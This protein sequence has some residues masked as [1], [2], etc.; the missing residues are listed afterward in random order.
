MTEIKKGDHLRVRIEKLIKGGAGLA[1][2]EG[3]VVFVDSAAPGDEVAVEITEVKKNFARGRI[4][5]ILQP[6]ESRQTP[7]CPH[8]GLCGGCHWQHIAYPIQI[9]AKQSILQDVIHRFLKEESLS[10]APLIKSPAPFHYRNRIQVKVEKGQ[11]GFYARGSHELV[12]IK[13]CLIAEEAINGALK[14]LAQSHP[15]DGS[16]RLQKNLDGKVSTTNIESLDEPLGFAQINEPLNRE[17]Q[18]LITK[19]Y[20]RY[21]GSIVLDLYGGYGNFSLPLAEKFPQLPI[22]TVEWSRQATEEAFRQAGKLKSSGL[23]IIN[24][25]VG[26]YLQ[27]V[28]V[29]SDS[30]VILDPPRDGCSSNVIKSLAQQSPRVLVYISC[31]P[32]TWGRDCQLF[33]AEARAQ[34]QDY[35]IATIHGLDMFPQTDHIEVF[36]VIERFH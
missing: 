18:S 15:S 27:R 14:A 3:Q 34:G 31:D 22:V 30:F 17:L 2:Y 33:L 24:S 9:E 20:E 35:R 11:I 16:Y 36:S 5:E 1:R 28:K 19:A 32:A 25:D 12:P 6:S 7:R 29:T 23:C 13:E 4:R 8:F 26:R 21:G 10:L